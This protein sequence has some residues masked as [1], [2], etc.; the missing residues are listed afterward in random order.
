MKYRIRSML[1]AAY[2]NLGSIL[3]EQGRVAEAE[4]AFVQALRYRP[5]MADV[6]YNLSYTYTAC[7]VLKCD[8][9]ILNRAVDEAD[10]S[11]LIIS[12]NLSSK[13]TRD[14]PRNV[15]RI[16][17]KP[18]S[19]PASHLWLCDR[20]NN[21]DSA[22]RIGELEPRQRASGMRHRAKQQPRAYTSRE[23]SGELA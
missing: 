11:V 23:P 20:R 10:A 13:L 2:G 15:F 9:G 22:R 12:I 3:S 14:F 7:V 21:C 1:L 4:E 6:H 8:V 16:L 5:N 17:N 19:Q 18:G